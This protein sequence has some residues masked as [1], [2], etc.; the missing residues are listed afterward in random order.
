[1]TVG[2]SRGALRGM[3]MDMVPRFSERNLPNPDAAETVP[4]K[5]F[6]GGPGMVGRPRGGAFGQHDDGEAEWVGGQAPGPVSG[7]ARS[8]N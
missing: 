2:K 4:G 3:W 5:G 7:V 1:M 6:G 8:V